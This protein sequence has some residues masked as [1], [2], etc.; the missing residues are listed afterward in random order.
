MNRSRTWT[1]LILLVATL[2]SAVTVAALSIRSQTESRPVG[3]S[4]DQP[5][6]ADRTAP[7]GSSG[8][9]RTG[10]EGVDARVGS[11]STRVT[12]FAA[13]SLA[14]VLATLDDAV[15]S[16]ELAANVAGSHYLAT[17][18]LA[19]AQFDLFLSA[20]L[21]QVERLRQDV[22]FRDAPVTPLFENRLVLVAWAQDGPIADTDQAAV[23][24]R[25]EGDAV[26]RKT[27]AP[28]GS[29]GAGAS[30]LKLI[31]EQGWT[32]IL[33]DP[34]VPLGRY[35]ERYL[36]SALERGYL[37][38]EDV[39]RIR[40]A[41]VSYEENARMVA[42]KFQLRAADAA[43]M[44]ATDAGLLPADSVPRDGDADA[45]ARKAI[46]QW[47]LSLADNP[48]YYALVSPRSDRRAAADQLV[49]AL[50]ED[51]GVISALN[52]AGYSHGQ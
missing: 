10:P 18:I 52:I 40:E 44:Y 1:Y 51:P 45:H 41:V 38:Q 48:T 39:S 32:L 33:A 26:D 25:A 17:Q 30:A 19:G 14:P 24:V 47:P 37:T 21:R 5:V 12:V 23:S 29:S 50:V 43:V 31:T 7:G 3:L 35:T 20:D 36:Q 16:V 6:G 4:A 34:Q 42:T 28:G 2:A 49:R 8:A 11:G 27:D 22:R 13:S 15:D 9:G 46:H